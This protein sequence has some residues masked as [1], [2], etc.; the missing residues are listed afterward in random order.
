VSR[1]NG[2]S[3]NGIRKNDRKMWGAFLK[4]DS[5]LENDIYIFSAQIYSHPLC[6]SH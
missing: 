4:E 5:L 1:E 2:S 3:E 6:N